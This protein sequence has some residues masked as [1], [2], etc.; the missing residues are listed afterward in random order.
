MVGAGC[1]YVSSVPVFAVTAMTKNYPEFCRVAHNNI[2]SLMI[3][4]EESK[5]SIVN[6]PLSAF[7]SLVFDAKDYTK[8]GII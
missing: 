6:P 1:I 4:L 8:N 3:I 5:S 7:Y 2:L